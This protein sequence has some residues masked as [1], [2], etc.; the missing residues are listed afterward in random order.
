MT[1]PRSIRFEARTLDRLAAYADRHLG[2]TSSS[3]AALLVE[4]GLR[5]DAHPGVVFRDG[6][7]G[8]RAVLTAGPDVWE[9][10]RAIRSARA[11]QPRLSP[12]K[13]VASLSEATGLSVTAVQTAIDYYAVFPDEIDGRIDA[14]SAAE[15]ELMAALEASERLLGA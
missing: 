12:A 1:S 5:M 10:V 11:E 2:L 13:I 9:V 4:E 8:R 14:E 6:P 15:T 3:A 7:A